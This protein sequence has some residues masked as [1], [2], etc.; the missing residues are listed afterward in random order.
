VLGAHERDGSWYAWVSWTQSAGHPVRHRH[1]V[2]C[3]RAE[4]A[5]EAAGDDLL[6]LGRSRS[7]EQPDIFGCMYGRE[8]EVKQLACAQ[9]RAVVLAGDP[10]VGKSMVLA[11][12][13]AQAD[14][15]GRGR[16]CAGYD[17]AQPRS[18]SDRASGC[19]GGSSGVDDPRGRSGP[20]GGPPLGRRSAP[21]G[22]SAARRT[23]RRPRARCSS[24]LYEP[25]SAV[26]RPGRAQ[27][28]VIRRHW[29]RLVAASIVETS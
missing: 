13:Q 21:D 6:N 2:V 16:A 10:R 17:P 5:P 24:A 12:G 20:D 4:S 29:H 11:A 8:R 28:H 22:E 19:A 7:W 25:G 9:P 27:H 15:A 26:R 14:A 1:Q 3:L 18:A 23:P